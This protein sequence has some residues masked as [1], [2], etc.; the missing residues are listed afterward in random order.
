MVKLNISLGDGLEQLKELRGKL[1]QAGAPELLSDAEWENRR[2]IIPHRTMRD[3][4]S[5][6]PSAGFARSV[7]SPRTIV[8]RVKVS[9]PSA[10]LK[11]EEDVL[12]DEEF[13]LIPELTKVLEECLVVFPEVKDV[14]IRV[15]LGTEL[16]GCKGTH[17]GKPIIILFVPDQAWGQWPVLRPIILHELAHFLAKTSEETEK[18]FF[19]RA[20]EKS[21]EL[22]HKLKNVDAIN[23]QVKKV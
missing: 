23:C 11:V 6:P 19:E 22:W 9:E 12:F 8:H 20:D 3:L 1:K 15:T 10:S 5:I 14:E 17:K 18:I 4:G 2:S 13:Q 21:K 7:H 16:S